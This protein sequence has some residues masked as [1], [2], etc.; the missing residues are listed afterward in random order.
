MTHLAWRQQL[1]EHSGGYVRGHTVT[2]RVLVTVG[3]VVA[4]DMWFAPAPGSALGST[5][6]GV[7]LMI[8][9]GSSSV[10]ACVYVYD[11]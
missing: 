6:A 9:H 3:A 8:V 7:C 2:I 5:S 11:R 10:R 4:V 1:R